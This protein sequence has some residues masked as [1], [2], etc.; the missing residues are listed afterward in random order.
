MI[1]KNSSN[2]TIPNGTWLLREP[3]PIPGTD[4]LTDF[5]PF[6]GPSPRKQ[7]LLK[8]VYKTLM[9]LNGKLETEGDVV[10]GG[11]GIRIVYRGVAIIA[12]ES[13]FFGMTFN[14]TINALTALLIYEEKS[15]YGACIG[16]IY[17]AESWRH[18]ETIGFICLRAHGWGM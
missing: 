10:I 12:R 17:N 6:P 9:Y 1:S 13:G 3:V 2:I 11:D 5:R 7:D 14:D 15:G 16:D 18:M 8:A 4:L